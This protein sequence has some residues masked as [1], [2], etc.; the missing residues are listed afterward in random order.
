[1][2]HKSRI[3][4]PS[5]STVAAYL[6]LFGVIAGGSAYAAAKIG[7]D[8]I[9]NDA[10]LSK[11]IKADQVKAS[12]IAGNAKSFEAVAMISR[13]GGSEGASFDEDH[14]KERGFDSVRSEGV[15]SYCIVAS[16]NLDPTK[17]PPIVTIEYN[18]SSGENFTAMW[19]IEGNNAC[20]PG[21]YDIQTF[22]AATDSNTDN[23]SFVIM[24]P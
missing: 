10:V 6:A 4:V 2:K 23:A 5:H 12:E 19:D 15:G 1:M 16:G 9:K 8:D 7:S 24:V 3:S 11:H 21:E 13:E 18:T 20:D 22:D 17:N 14:I